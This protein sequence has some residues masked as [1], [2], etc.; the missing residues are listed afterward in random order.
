MG[1]LSL[2]ILRDTLIRLPSDTQ[3]MAESKTP[4]IGRFKVIKALGRGSQGAVYLARDPD[5]DRLVAV[6]LV[7]E[8][9]GEAATTDSWP[10]ARN[11]AQLRH[12][13]II[14]LYELGKFHTVTYLVFE[15]LEGT[16]LRS[17][18]TARGAL[19]VPDA[20]SL[21]TQLADAMAY[22]HAK[23]ILHLDLN[24]NNIMRDEEGKPRIMDFD[25][26]RRVD[27]KPVTKLITGTPPYMAPEHFQSRQLDTRTDVYALGQIFYELLTGTLAVPLDEDTKMIARICRH[28]ADFDLP[29]KAD[30]SGLLVDVIRRATFKD[31]D[32]RFA[33]AREFHDA[34]SAAWAK[35]QPKFQQD[36]AIVHGT[37]AFVMKRI[38]RKGEFPAVS[39]TLAEVNQLTSD[40]SQ[41][42]VSKLSGVVLRDFA[43][44]NRLLK[45][46]NSP[47]YARGGGQIKSVSDAINVLGIEQVRLT[48]NGLTCFGHFTGK[49][50][51]LRLREA[52]ITAFLAGLVARHLAVEA[53][54]KQGETA[55]LA[56]M[57]FNL[58]KMLCMYYF[59]DSHEDIEDLMARGATEEMAS[60]SVMGITL[61]QMGHAVGIAWGLPDVV[62]R[63]MLNEV[64]DDMPALPSVVRF[65][66]A[67]VHVDH[68]RNPQN[69]L[70]NETS[71]T[72]A[73]FLSISDKGR[74]TL[75]KAAL[76]KFRGFA[77]ALDVDTSTS[78]GARRIEG[79]L[80]DNAVAE[81]PV[82]PE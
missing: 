82:T 25:L 74:V 67:L 54:I 48:C 70:L 27:V 36:D 81:Q 68:E 7:S 11:L 20:L 40:D 44:T 73:P 58:G 77:P 53:G 51:D 57:L 56:S 37:V 49:S 2:P 45:I 23:G 69:Q 33:H 3:R 22:A 72:L 18:L 13:N 10:Q 30:P 50:K 16:P 52:C 32:K 35:L 5:L 71:V 9:A 60:R 41:S 14:A 78:E 39:K 21:M 4:Q 64:C 66:N 31:S 8:M 12:P 79:W 61:A 75:L 47:Y 62:L 19:P 6:K 43:L 26:S 76:D 29:R 80:K 15:Y 1:S 42:P 24:P 55:F 46:A 17:E 28:D 63:C 34:L 38:E 59:T 65:A